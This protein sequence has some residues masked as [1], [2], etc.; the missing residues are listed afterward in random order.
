MSAELD[1]FTLF[2]AYHLGITEE[3]VYRWQNGHQVARRFGLELDELMAALQAHG[4]DPDTLLATGFDLA[5]AQADV[6][7]SPA[8][9]DLIGL[10]RMHF[11]ALREMEPRGRDWAAEL[12]EDAAANARVFGEDD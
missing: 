4:L 8:G 6:Q 11:D 7:L 10:A 1:A 2:C 12:A 9:V 3:N 5:S